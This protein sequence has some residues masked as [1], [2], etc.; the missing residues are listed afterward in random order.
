M[1]ISR[2]KRKQL[3]SKIGSF[4]EPFALGILCLLFIIPALTFSN[5]TPIV[6]ELNSNVLGV[7][8]ETGFNIELVGGSHNVFQGEHLV[9]DS[10]I[11]YSYDSKILAH[12]SGSFSKPILII[13]NISNE[14]QDIFFSG[15]TEIPIQS[16]IGLI[17][18]DTF[19]ELQNEDGETTKQTLTIDP[20]STI[21][22]FLSVE[23]FTD[24]QFS[25]VF[26]MN[27]SFN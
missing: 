6:K 9:K 26:Y 10:D 12:K 14:K 15:S 7:Q 27:V 2:N 17:Y 13:E 4:L 23:S 18:N 20:L 3:V 25:E 21:T 11:L 8:D 24:V 22:V 16:R 1:Y 19:F 5:L